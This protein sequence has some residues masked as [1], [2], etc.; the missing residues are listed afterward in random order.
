LTAKKA[1]PKG[2]AFLFSEIG[3][4]MMKKCPPEI[5]EP[6]CARRGAF[7]ENKK[8]SPEGEGFWDSKILPERGIVRFPEFRS[9]LSI[10]QQ[11][12]PHWDMLP[13]TG[14]GARLPLLNHF[15]GEY[16]LFVTTLEFQNPRGW[17]AS[18]TRGP[19]SGSA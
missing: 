19:G 5:P 7:D 18:G 1:A 14:Y 8:P 17:K 10:R 15:G 16:L 3:C 9:Y 4:G 13:V 12:F 11:E 2:A 6:D